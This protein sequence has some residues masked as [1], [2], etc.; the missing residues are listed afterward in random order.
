M[1]REPEAAVA[2]RHPHTAGWLIRQ[3]TKL[4]FNGK[5]GCLLILVLI[6][7]LLGNLDAAF[8]TRDAIKRSIDSGLIDQVTGVHQLLQQEL[9]QAPEQ[10][11]QKTRP[12]LSGLRW[13][14]QGSGYFFL[15]D[16]QGRLL[17]YPPKAT[18]EGG[19]LDPAQVSETGEE[20]SQAFARIGRGDE[21]TL[22]HYPYTKPG[23][24]QKTLKAVYVAPLGDYLLISGVYMDAADRA[25]EQYLVRS[26]LVLLGTLVVMVLRIG[27]ISR[28][29]NS[30]VKQSLTELRLIANRDLSRTIYGL[31]RDEFADI[32]RELEHTRRNLSE[33]LAG[34][35]NTSATLS[36]ASS[37]MNHGMQQV[38][39]AVQDQ[40]ERLDSLATAMEEMS[41]TIRDVALNA[42]RSANDN[43]AADQMVRRGVEQLAHCIGLIRKL[44][45][46]LNTSAESVGQVEH[47]VSAI[48]SVVSTISGISEQ[49]NLL[50][51]NAAIEAARAGEHGRGFAVV[52]DEVRQLA[53][54][55]QQATHE[56][57]EMI[58]SLQQGTQ[59]AVQQMQLSVKDAQSAVQDA[60][61]A[62]QEFV[63]IS[64]QIGQQAQLSDMIAA[65]AEQQSTV[66]S[67]VTDSLVVIRDA[68]EET[69]QVVRELGQ[70]S[71]SLQ[72]EAQGLEQ[73]VSSYRLA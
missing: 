14:E 63:A 52:A 73:M 22:I 27:I 48:G 41:A 61:S 39:S 26:S 56:I 13:G 34:Q 28:A 58:S 3:S 51:L 49:T 42:Q 45:T 33:L 46:T 59:Q 15:A 57:D 32:N 60:E 6:C 71:D 68:V 11:L 53:R 19:F 40:R 29:I 55:T 62:N 5:M 35:R 50:A 36:A 38:G 67:Q 65:A 4:R 20:V 70:A 31:G 44:F 66:A 64:A 1:Y 25:F 37:Q 23:S 43:N 30:Q 47:E 12:L 9:Q 69:E 21:P 18:K 24:S 72:Q 8:N 17:I 2:S 54:R 10:F 16:R 7:T